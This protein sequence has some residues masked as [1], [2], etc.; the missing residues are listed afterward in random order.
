[1]QVEVVRSAKRRKTIS[2]RQVGDV[3][4]VSIPATMTK[5]EEE[6]WVGEMVRRMQRHSTADSIDLAERAASLAAR[7]GLPRPDSIRWVDNQA[8]RWGSCTPVDRSVRISSRVAGFPP[9]VVD[10]VIV[11]ELAHLVVAGHNRRFWAL[12]DRYP[13]AERAKGFLI[14][15]GLEGDDPDP[16][17]TDPDPEPFWAR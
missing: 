11:H 14:A 7:F 6:R 17:P 10:Y 9:W 15:K 5:A 2:A 12:V 16:E 3:L 8:S 13:R 4:R 1:V